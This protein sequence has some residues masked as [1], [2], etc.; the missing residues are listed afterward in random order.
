M[1]VKQIYS[2][3]NEI[4]TE[5][6]GESVLLKEDLSN[7]VD[8]GTAVF[9]ANAY[10]KYV[11]KIVDKIGKTIIVDR[12]Y[13]GE[14]PSVIMDSW[15]FGSV[16]E[17]IRFGLPTAQEN[18]TWELRDGESYNQDIFKAPNVEVKF[19]NMKT[20]FEVQLSVTDIQLRSAF[21]SREAMNKFL[22][23]LYTSV[24]NA[25]TL[26][27]ENLVKATIRN[28][29]G[30]AYKNRSAYAGCINVLAMYNALHS[31]A[32]L[33]K[34]EA[35]YNKEFIRFAGYV[36]K[37]TINKIQSYSTLYNVGKT[38]KFTPKEDLHVV[39]LA[40][41]KDLADIYLQ[42]D[43]FHDEFT[44]LPMAEVVNYW[45]GSGESFALADT[46]KIN[47]TTAS[48]TD[49]ELDYIIG[50]LFDRNALGV[51]NLERRVPTHRNDKAEFTNLFYKQT[52]GYFNDLNENF[53]L[54]Y[55]A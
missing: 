25:L 10:E 52:A 39:L 29:M 11:G 21:L 22:S 5:T 43:T 38:Q 42:S 45:Q 46:T 12:V 31:G 19:F 8:L 51:T 24:E 7:I 32:T 16:V 15:E 55:L 35:L 27:M 3:L 34:A 17:K 1:E 14:L 48:G 41:F 49:V 40:E 37:S 20:T 28:F 33:T 36:I 47:V 44:E 9:N 53:V 54:F 2:L 30:E 4:N 13:K 23:G 26:S 6:L 50:V 18:E